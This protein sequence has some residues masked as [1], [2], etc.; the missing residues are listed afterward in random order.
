MRIVNLVIGFALLC[1]P[2]S[3]TSLT[4]VD[5][6]TT[7]SLELEIALTVAGDSLTS[8]ML[9]LSEAERALAKSLIAQANLKDSLQVSGMMQSGLRLQLTLAGEQNESLTSSFQSY[10]A[11]IL[12]G[13]RKQQRKYNILSN[14][15][16]VGGGIAI[17]IIL[18]ETLILVVR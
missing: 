15:I 2:L 3:S 13:A 7:I 6:L 16:K 5:E 10:K 17:A 1:L 9:H 11:Q 12:E 18:L 8:L 4:I 14:I